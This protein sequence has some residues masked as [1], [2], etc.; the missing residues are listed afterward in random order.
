M[1]HVR[2]VALPPLDV[3]HDG[4]METDAERW[5]QR[6]SAQTAD[7]DPSAAASPD[8]MLAAPTLLAALPTS[9]T[10]LDLACGTGAQSLWL[11]S[12]GYTVTALDVSGVAIAH[13]ERSAAHAGADVDAR[14]WDAAEGL[15]DD[16]CDLAVIVCQRY[17]SVE[18]YGELIERLRPGGVLLLT[19]L[20]AVGAAGTPGPFHA[21]AGELTTAFGTPDRAVQPA[22]GAGSEV[23]FA[24]EEDGQASIAVRRLPARDASRRE[25]N[26]RSSATVSGRQQQSAP[27]RRS[28]K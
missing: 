16:V 23:L 24:V 21:P 15:P 13:V 5:D 8:I 7:T 18:L 28:Q 4:V 27:I 11:A 22:G 2:S 19:V 26:L 17:R 10:A 6:W 25:P 14:V 20:S 3:W 12:L 1:T 9:G